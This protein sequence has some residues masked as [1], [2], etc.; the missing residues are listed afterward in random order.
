MQIVGSEQD[1]FLYFLELE[2]DIEDSD[3]GSGLKLK[4]ISND[5]WKLWLEAT[6][7]YDENGRFK[8]S[9]HSGK[10]GTHSTFVPMSP[11]NLDS[12]KI[13]DNN[14]V[15]TGKGPSTRDLVEKIDDGI[16]LYSTG[17]SGVTMGLSP[18]QSLYCSPIPGW[19]ALPKS[20]LYAKDI[21]TLN[22]L[23]K[24]ISNCRESKFLLLFDRYK[25][26]IQNSPNIGIH[27]RFLD[28]VTILEILLVEDGNRGEISYKLRMRG[29]KIFS[30][31]L[32]ESP[33]S[34]YEWFKN[35]Y[36]LRSKITHGSSDLSI[37][38]NEW[39]R[40]VDTVRHGILK[41]ME[42]PSEFT[43]TRLDALILD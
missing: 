3:L 11:Y 17:R 37:T 5:D 14:Y 42:N 20:K 9:I 21:P 34:L 22:T 12:V 31:I 4:R 24:T 26:A 16:R 7:T 27:N 33:A 19:K 39:F 10:N 6:P 2:S 28:L 40:L 29:S 36:N 18:R 15:I 35:I 32:N 23:S 41:Y 13:F 8:T 1:Q 43:S 25:H 30:K 38:E